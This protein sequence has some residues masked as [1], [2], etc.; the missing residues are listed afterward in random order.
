MELPMKLSELT[1]AI[2]LGLAAPALLLFAAP[3]LAQDAAAEDEVAS[4][5]DRITVTGSRIKRVDVEGPSPVTVIDAAQI[6]REGFTTVFEV[7]NSLTQATGNIQVE[8]DAGTFTQNANGLNLRNLGPGR[9]LTLING[10]RAT[11]Y[12]LPFNGQSNLVNFGSI[13]AAAVERI[14]VLAGGASAIY[15]SDAVAGVINIILRRDFEGILLNARVGGTEDGGGSSSRFQAVGGQ[16]TGGLSLTWAF[17]YLDRKPIWAFQ[18][19]FQDSLA[20][21]PRLTGNVVNSRNVLLLD[22]F[23]GN[24][25]GLTYIDPGAAA[26]NAFGPELSY[27]FRGPAFGNYCGRP[28]DIAQQTLRN[29]REN[30]SGMLNLAYALVADKEAY[31]Q[32]LVNQSDAEFNTGTPFWTVLDANFVIDTG[33]T[34]WFGVG[35]E[36]VVPQRIFTNR[37]TGGRNTNNQS[38]DER[39]WSAVLGLKGVFGDGRFDY[40][41]SYS[42][43]AYDLTR[44]RRLFIAEAID[45]YYLGPRLGTGIFGAPVHRLNRQRLFSPMTPDVYRSLTDI[46]RTEAD[47]S[48][49]VLSAVVT[50]ELWELPGGPMGFAAVA[51]WGTQDYTIDLDDRLVAG[52]F[53]GFTGTGGGGERDRYALGIEFSLPLHDTFNATAAARWD[54]YDDITAVDDAITYNLGIE[55]RPLD[56]LLVRG[57]YATSFRAP[58]MHFVFADPSGFFS[59]A[60]DEFLCRRDEPGVDLDDCTYANSQFRGSRQGDPNLEEEEGES[61]T[62]GLVWNATDALSMS[63]DYYDIKLEGIINDLSIAYII[64]READCRLGV[65]DDGSPVDINS[66]ECR[67]IISRVVRA[68]ADGS[69]FSETLVSIRTGPINRAVQRT[70]G[71]DA[72]LNYLMDTDNWGAFRYNLGWSHVFSDEQAQFPGDPVLDLRDAQLDL[73]SRMRGSVTWMKGDWS[74]TLFASRFGSALIERQQGRSASYTRFNLTVEHRFSDALTGRIAVQNVFDKR[75]IRDTF[76]FDAYPWY[77]TSI[78]DPTGREAFVEVE[79]RF[80]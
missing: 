43:A 63:V 8:Q 78:Y 36:T 60:D 15:G 2:A 75:P 59:A 52:D 48:N 73:R 69:Q 47:S 46:D 32:V 26:C 22:P 30:L 39:N 29:A 20:D 56:S 13:P 53:W 16:E 70:K 19:D 27:S 14:E 38:F 77:T 49:D 42:H 4:E 28:D 35:G 62:V 5:L 79:Y 3:T 25:D 64:D 18:R 9:S 21:N 31:A 58:D 80:N 71:V 45:N 34:D 33:G 66:G 72:E 50:G 1:R 61:F 54:K 68:P 65:D 24:D 10:R 11:D 6:Q 51:E 40:D 12:P 17:E 23:D 7:L 57:A 55:W 41:L 37:E 44:E 76:N 67:D 74:T